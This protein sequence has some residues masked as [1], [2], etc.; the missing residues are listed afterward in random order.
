[1]DWG[2]SPA[3]F[4]HEDEVEDE[5]P[6]EKHA[7]EE[8]APDRDAAPEA[9]QSDKPPTKRRGDGFSRWFARALLD[10]IAASPLSRAVNK[11]SP[12]TEAAEPEEEVPPP[13]E[14]SRTSRYVGA[15]LSAS[16]WLRQHVLTPSLRPL[17]AV[18]RYKTPVGPVAVLLTLSRLRRRSI[19]EDAASFFPRSRAARSLDLDMGDREYALAGGVAAE[20]ASVCVE[21]IARHREAELEARAD[22]NA[23][24]GEVAATAYATTLIELL[25]LSCPPRGSRSPLV[26]KTGEALSRL[27]E[28]R[29]RAR[30][31]VASWMG[32]IRARPRL[33]SAVPRLLS[34]GEAVVEVRALDALLRVLRERLLEVAKELQQA[35]RRATIR[36]RR[37]G[38]RL[39]ARR[40][41]LIRTSAQYQA[42]LRRI[43]D[44]QSALLSR[45]SLHPQRGSEAWEED[46]RRWMAEAQSVVAGVVGGAAAPPWEG[47][48]AA[49]PATGVFGNGTEPSVLS[50]WGEAGSREGSTSDSLVSVLS[51]AQDLPR[52]Q[53]AA[54]EKQLVVPTRAARQATSLP[55]SVATLA[56]AYGVHRLLSPRWDEIKQQALFLGALGVDLF[57]QK[58][59]SPLRTLVVDLLSRK[60]RLIT[61]ANVTEDAEQS[62]D[63]MLADLTGGTSNRT[64][65]LAAASRLY[66]A[67]LRAGT[68]KGLLSGRMVRLIL[69]QAQLLKLQSLR[70][71]G[72]LDDLVDAN[73]LNV[74]LFATLPALLLALLAWRAAAAAGYAVRARGLR[75]TKDVHAEMSDVLL[76]MERALLLAEAR[77]PHGAHAAVMPDASTAS[78]EPGRAWLPWEAVPAQ[79]AP[80][81]P[82]LRGAELG[83]FCVLLHSYLRMLDFSTPPLSHR[84]ADAI[85]RELQELL[86]GQLSAARQ[87]AMMRSV[88]TRHARLL[89]GKVGAAL[90]MVSAA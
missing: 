37:G 3:T 77:E 50:G 25:Q 13:P 14:P 64:E 81:P 88:A 56:L 83:E 38:L 6:D 52:T 84:A 71:M 74:S 18:L 79:S 10:W 12:S 32:G 48:A 60:S 40:E 53:R 30:W 45:P 46:A 23:T 78:P 11:M 75:S 47:K 80:P 21:A 58:F 51:L 15:A 85:H 1:M 39:S 17:L 29:S 4:D 90:D 33:G 61:E 73:R 36:A 62:L 2:D 20:R 26:S 27:E 16:L 76:K 43:G 24:E 54:L 28:L 55:Q 63:N 69:I 34:E 57:R 87:Q 82:V 65:A 8:H 22:R 89:R 49:G 44:V 5:M 42:Q 19:L 9:S 70:A 31:P 35:E 72:T 67:G 86:W 68:L 41:R 66:E 7:D 59:Y